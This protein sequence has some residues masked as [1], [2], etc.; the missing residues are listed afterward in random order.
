VTQSSSL[1]DTEGDCNKEPV[2]KGLCG[3]NGRI[4]AVDA[5]CWATTRRE[6][7]SQLPLLLLRAMRELKANNDA[8]MQE[9]E[10]PEGPETH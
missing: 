5:S 1:K 8:V 9:V 10:E 7:Q 3:N 2:K 4:L 6:I